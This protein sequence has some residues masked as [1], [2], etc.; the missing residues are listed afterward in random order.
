MVMRGRTYGGGK[1]GRVQWRR[2]R[3]RWGPVRCLKWLAPAQ[4]RK[5]ISGLGSPGRIGWTRLGDDAAQIILIGGSA[6]K[7]LMRRFYST[8][9]LYEPQG[10]RTN[11]FHLLVVSFIR[12]VKKTPQ[13]G[14]FYA[15]QTYLEPPHVCKGESMSHQTISANS[16]P[17]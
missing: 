6:V 2:I 15:K 4:T 1:F 17:D 16:M 8:L 5:F 13:G 11:R 12:I 10:G 7:S 3:S 9:P 14:L